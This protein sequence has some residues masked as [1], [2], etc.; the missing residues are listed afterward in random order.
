LGHVSYGK[1]GDSDF[2]KW[3]NDQ[4]AG[5]TVRELERVSERGPYSAYSSKA[6]DRETW[7]IAHF[8]E[9]GNELFNRYKLPPNT[10]KFVIIK[11]PDGP[12]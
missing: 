6:A 12:A 11:L 8:I 2:A 3:I 4:G 10:D 1:Y 5:L 9:Q 7:W